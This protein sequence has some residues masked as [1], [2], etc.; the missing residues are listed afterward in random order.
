MLAALA[1][2]GA[3]VWLVMTFWIVI[4]VALGVAMAAA[5]AGGVWLA[6]HGAEAAVVSRTPLPAPERA[7]I[8]SR[9]AQALQAPQST[10]TCMAR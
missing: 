8:A 10:C 9:P 6:R 7:P 3:V 1:A 2:T 5:V 4:A